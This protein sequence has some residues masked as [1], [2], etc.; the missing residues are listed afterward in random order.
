MSQLPKREYNEAPLL[1]GYIPHGVNPDIFRKITD[2]V[3][4]E[5]DVVRHRTRL[6]GAVIPSFV[7]FYNNRNIRRKMT[8]DV[9]LAFA[10]FWRTLP[11]SQRATVFMLLHTQP[12]DEN[13]TDLPRVIEDVMPDVK[14]NIVFSTERLL[15]KDL[16]AVYNLSDVVINL[17]SNEGFGIGTLEGMM[18]ERLMLAN[19]TGGLQDQMGFRDEDGKYLHEDIHFKEDWGSNHTGKYQTCG[20]WAFPV[21]PNNRSLNGSVPTPY[22]FDD[23]CDWNDA[24]DQ[25][26]KIYDLPADERARRGQL[27]RV[28]AMEE[29]YNIAEMNNRFIAGFNHL[30]STWTPR[31]R[32]GVFQ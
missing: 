26:R 25:L 7:V 5:A 17:A 11:E 18:A 23:R 13:G 2:P 27:A 24:A 19:V 16:N 12:V 29:G 10:T 28:Y 22:I 20:D 32:F 21:F 8:S 30:L 9:L 4:Y 6:F 15:P 31:E 3:E 1:I 14:Q